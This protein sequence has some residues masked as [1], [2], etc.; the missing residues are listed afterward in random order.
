MAVVDSTNLEGDDSQIEFSNPLVKVNI[1]MVFQQLFLLTCQRSLSKP[2]SH[3]V[4]RFI[5]VGTKT[6]VSATVE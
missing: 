4:R 2:D 3:I 1:V 5:N 6:N